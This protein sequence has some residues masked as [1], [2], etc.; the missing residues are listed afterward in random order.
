MMK[1]KE[2]ELEQYGLKPPF[3]CDWCYGEKKVATHS[4]GWGNYSKKLPKGRPN[5]ICDEC[6]AGRVAEITEKMKPE[7]YVPDED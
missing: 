2:G 6:E 1:I 3:S 4:R 5:F 7:P